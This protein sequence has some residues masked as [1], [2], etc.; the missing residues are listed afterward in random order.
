LSSFVSVVCHF[1]DISYLFMDYGD[2]GSTLDNH[3]I[4]HTT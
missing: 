4:V 2:A 1:K 3:F